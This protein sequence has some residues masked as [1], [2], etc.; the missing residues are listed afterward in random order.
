MHDSISETR[1]PIVIYR[2]NL[3]AVGYLKLDIVGL[4]TLFV[5]IHEVSSQSNACLN[6]NA[7]FKL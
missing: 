5:H 7:V 6:S 3:L 4:L 1:Q 2:C